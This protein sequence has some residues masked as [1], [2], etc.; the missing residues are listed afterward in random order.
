MGKVLYETT[1]LAAEL[2]VVELSRADRP[3]AVGFYPPEFLVASPYPHQLS[4]LGHLAPRRPGARMDGLQ[5]PDRHMGLAHQLESVH[6]PRC[7]PKDA[8]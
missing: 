8:E 5:V 3:W 7:S 4:G 2:R 6:D 1:S